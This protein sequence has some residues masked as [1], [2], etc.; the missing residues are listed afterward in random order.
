MKN[1][2]SIKR[3]KREVLTE[4]LDGLREIEA[5][6][7]ME[8]FARNEIKPEEEP[9]AETPEEEDDEY[10]E[11]FS[12]PSAFDRE[13][14]EVAID[15]FISHLV[16]TAVIKK[17]EHR[18]RHPLSDIIQ[19]LFGEDHAISTM[20]LSFEEHIKGYFDLVCYD[21]MQKAYFELSNIRDLIQAEVAKTK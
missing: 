6:F 15:V 5:H 21:D 12:G 9:Q 7:E 14:I 10:G 2:K 18:G 8:G 13:D 17:Q 11:D 20:T 3:P 16:Q 4:I 19:D 1:R